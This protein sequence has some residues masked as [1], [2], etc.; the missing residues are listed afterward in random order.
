MASCKERFTNI[1][2]TNICGVR[3]V[4]NALMR[5]STLSP[6]RLTNECDLPMGLPAH[7]SQMAGGRPFLSTVMI[8]VRWTLAAS[9]WT[10]AAAYSI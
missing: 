10:C 8:G 3:I 6:T 4:R 9:T 2:F 7:A 5:Y 1:F